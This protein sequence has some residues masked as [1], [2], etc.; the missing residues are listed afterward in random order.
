MYRQQCRVER[1]HSIHAS[2]NEQSGMDNWLLST[3]LDFKVYTDGHWKMVLPLIKK[4]Y[5]NELK[6]GSV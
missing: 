6:C 1:S 4:T 3:Q 2:F 5:V